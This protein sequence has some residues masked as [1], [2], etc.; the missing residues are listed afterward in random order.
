MITAEQSGHS[1]SDD[2]TTPK[3]RINPARNN[4]IPFA[5]AETVRN[6]E[7]R[8]HM[9]GQDCDECRNWH[10]AT[11]HIP[12]VDNGPKWRDVPSEER[13][14]EEDELEKNRQKHMD[15]VSR[16]RSDVS[17][18]IVL[19]DRDAETRMMSSHQR[20]LISFR[21][22]SFL[23]LSLLLATGKPLSQPLKKS[24]RGMLKLSGRG[25]RS[26]R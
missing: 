19:W 9:Q 24:R 5:Y 3:F 22:L 23:L 11:K 20:T 25:L 26:R 1:Y 6:K 15:Q 2:T 18:G 12:I 8:R 16:H 13:L 17:G 14:G 21:F 7:C 4:G 10:D